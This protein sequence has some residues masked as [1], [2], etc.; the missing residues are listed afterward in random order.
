MVCLRCAGCQLLH[1]YWQ[2]SEGMDTW[3]FYL[4]PLTCVLQHVSD[5]YFF[6]SPVL[7]ASMPTSSRGFN[8]ARIHSS[9]SSMLDARHTR[10]LG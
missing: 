10:L 2:R 3:G 8:N 1:G 4:I 7:T 5:L 6:S 9:R